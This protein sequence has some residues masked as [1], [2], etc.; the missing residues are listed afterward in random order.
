MGENSI[1]SGSKDFYSTDFDYSTLD[2]SL[3]MFP[4]P[5]SMYFC[6]ESLFLT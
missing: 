4:R 5:C 3:R 2:A 6:L 1:E